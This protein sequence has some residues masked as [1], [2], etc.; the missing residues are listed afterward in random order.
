MAFLFISLK[1]KPILKNIHKLT[2]SHLLIYWQLCT[3]LQPFFLLLWM[4]CP[5]SQLRTTYTP[6][7][8]FLI[9]SLVTAIIPAILVVPY[10]TMFPFQLVGSIDPTNMLICIPALKIDFGPVY[11]SRCHSISP[12]PFMYHNSWKCCAYSL[13]LYCFSSN[14]S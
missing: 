14:D 13:Y 9:D 4:R 12:L 5:C 6:S 2:L 7:A 1:T 3:S 11:C 10:I 8:R